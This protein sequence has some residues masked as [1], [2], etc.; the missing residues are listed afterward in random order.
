MNI[1]L[2]V[3]LGYAAGGFGIYAFRAK[4][5]IPLRFAATCG[6]AFGLAYGALRGAQPTILVNA[7]ML[8]LNLWR[9][10]EMRRL[11]SDSGAATHTDPSRPE[12]YDWLK[13][14]MHR[15]ELPAGHVLFRKGE[16]GN[17]A[18]LIGDGEVHIPE[19]DAYARPGDLLGEIGLLATDN[20]RSAT[21][22][23]RTAVRAWRVSYHELKELCL[24]NPQFCLHLATVIVRRF[25]HNLRHASQK[26]EA[27]AA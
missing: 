25:E 13:P 3:I 17:E 2:D 16:V 21:A 20:R 6:C 7:V 19:F 26:I 24:Q 23:C 8:A 9:L 15:V 22:V 12:G 10:I 5:M 11:I 27:P 4:T 18:F 14:F 1:S